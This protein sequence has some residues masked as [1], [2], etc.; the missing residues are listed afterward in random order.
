MTCLLCVSVCVCVMCVFLYNF[1]KSKDSHNHPQHS[2]NVELLYLHGS[3]TFK[4]SVFTVSTL[5][6]SGL[7]MNYTG[8]TYKPSGDQIKDLKKRTTWGYKR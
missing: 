5:S 4:T 2:Y 1:T 6:S 3:P 7:K 8:C